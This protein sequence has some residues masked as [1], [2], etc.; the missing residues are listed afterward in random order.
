M[1]PSKLAA[2][3]S[4]LALLFTAP[5]VAGGSI[6]GSISFTG[7]APEAKTVERKSDPV[8]AK[9][10]PLTDDSIVLS[11]DGTRLANVLVRITSGQPPAAPAE[12]VVINQT[13]CTYKPRVQG[14]I[15]GQKIQIK[16]GDPTLHN[17]HGYAGTRTIFNMAQPPKAPDLNKTI[18]DGDVV[19]LKC[20]VHPW[21]I[22]WVVFSKG[23]FA[24]SGDDGSYQIQ[25]LAPGQYTL[26]A[27]HEKLGTKTA[28]VTVEEGKAATVDFSFAA[29][30]N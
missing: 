23:P 18:A 5:V 22:S 14:A 7:P 2:A 29:H 12:P 13:G 1:S 26:E 24:R 27:W 20:D 16:N 8:C 21:M 3:T 4:G 15:V 10:G 25:S 28:Q 19:K 6:Q 30:T 11:K 9:A 17:V